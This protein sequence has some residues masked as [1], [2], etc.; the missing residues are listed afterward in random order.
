MGNFAVDREESMGGQSGGD[1]GER[2]D[3]RR[4]RGRRGKE[5]DQGGQLPSL[6]V[7]EGVS[8]DGPWCRTR[9]MIHTR[10]TKANL[11]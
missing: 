9:R 11:Q 3:R 1:D 5:D 4:E 8:L 10:R 7:E 6:E 2:K